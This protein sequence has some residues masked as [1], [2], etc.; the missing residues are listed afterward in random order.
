M[1][2]EEV[3]VENENFDAS[4][5]TRDAIR[6]ALIGNTPKILKKTI[7]IFDIGLELHQPTFGAIINAREIEDPAHRAASL[8]IEYSFVPGT[9]ERVFEDTDLEFI[10][11]W[12]FGEDLITI[13]NAI[14]E[15]TG[16]DIAAAEE[17]IRKNPLDEPS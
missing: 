6:A 3:K 14:A 13:Q 4:P 7:T 5:L 12:P 15:L 11:R 1:E 16:V 8:I 10:L 17:E 9:D 2:L